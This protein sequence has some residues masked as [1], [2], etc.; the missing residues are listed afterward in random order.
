MK[1]GVYPVPSEHFGW[2]QQR[3]GCVIT[4]DFRAMAALDGNGIIKAMVG[5]CCWTNTSAQVH[6]ATDTPFALRALV[7]DNDSPAFRYP[8][9]E[10]KKRILIGSVPSQNPRALKLNSH[11]GFEEV[12]RIKDGF[13]EGNDIVLMEMRKEN[14]R[15]LREPKASGYVAQIAKS[16]DD[17]WAQ[18]AR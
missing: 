2:I 18:E 6:F 5:Y 14:C 8:F 15:F 17:A 3:T 4:S 9:I 1:L 7:Y 16:L 10:A 13:G 11:F 12:A